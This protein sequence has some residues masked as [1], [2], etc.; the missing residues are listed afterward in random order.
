MPLMI[1]ISSSSPTISSP[2]LFSLVFIYSFF[3]SMVLAVYNTNVLLVFA[4][5]ENVDQ[6]CWGACFWF[7][8]SSTLLSI[9]F[10][11]WCRCAIPRILGAS[12]LLHF[13]SLYFISFFVVVVLFLYNVLFL[14]FFD[15]FMVPCVQVFFFSL[16]VA[17]YF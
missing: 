3:L 17:K 9:I 12:M 4:F 13:L 1:I 11:A 10:G 14:F 8:L 15:S 16:L 2:F 7:Y 6:H 5:F